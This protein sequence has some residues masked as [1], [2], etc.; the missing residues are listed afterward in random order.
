MEWISQLFNNY[1]KP[2][3]ANEYVQA[4]LWFFAAFILAKVGRY[5]IERLQVQSAKRFKRS[6][7]HHLFG[8]IKRP[9]SLTIILLGIHLGL[10]QLT[11]FLAL[12]DIKAIINSILIS[13]AVIFWLRFFVNFARFTLLE[14]SREE[15]GSRMVQKHTLPLFTNMVVILLYGAGVYFIFVA[16]DINV[17]AWVASA[18]IIGLALSFAAKDTLANLFA[19][20]FILA[21]TP[22]KLGD[23]IVLDSGERGMVTHIGIRSTRILTRSDVEITIPNAIMGNTKVIN[24]TAGPNTKYRLQIKVGV[25]YGTEIQLV[26]DTL[27]SIVEKN[28]LIEKNPQPQVRLRGFGDSSLNFE[29]LCWIS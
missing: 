13:I 26:R 6:L 27:L 19:G 5:I 3:L 9:V 24:E 25:A 15:S 8:A 29:L 22:Y 23:F 12:S 4:L 16:W 17:T 10:S 20:V 21:D 7:D 1:I 2:L 28:E 18:G 14:M 11:I